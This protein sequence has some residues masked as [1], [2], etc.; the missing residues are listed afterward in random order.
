MS[1]H[2]SPWDVARRAELEQCRA[3]F[4]ARPDFH[5]LVAEADRRGFRR[6]TLTEQMSPG[7]SD[8]FTWRGGV[9]VKKSP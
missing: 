8:A 6:I 7:Q 4:E 1:D 5:E 3:E 2:I 9:W